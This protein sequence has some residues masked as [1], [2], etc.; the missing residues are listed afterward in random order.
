MSMPEFVRKA[1]Q[2]SG[3]P[4]DELS[5]SINLYNTA[6]WTRRR[7]DKWSQSL[8][9]AERAEIRWWAELS[10][11]RNSNVFKYFL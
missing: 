10:C 1:I 9:L 5:Y 6:G 3:F 4:S 2:D 8:E 11:V 7:E